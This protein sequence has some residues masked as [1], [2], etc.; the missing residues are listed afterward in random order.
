MNNPDTIFKF[1]LAFIT[2]CIISFSPVQSRGL[3]NKKNSKP[4]NIG[5][6]MEIKTE[7]YNENYDATLETYKINIS[8]EDT[9]EDSSK[10][11]FRK[12]SKPDFLQNENVKLKAGASD[13]P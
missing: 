4:V 5:S 10:P 11:Y 13:E 1:S 9:L 2:S 6:Y 12:V 3:D 7:I 8:T